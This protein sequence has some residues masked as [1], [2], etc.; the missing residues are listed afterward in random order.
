M[1][2]FS[3]RSVAMVLLV[4]LGLTSIWLRYMQQGLAPA[5]ALSAQDDDVSLQQVKAMQYAPD[6][7]LSY[8]LQAQGYTHFPVRKQSQLQNL[9]LWQ[10][11]PVLSAGT[12][13]NDVVQLSA[14]YAVLEE[15]TQLLRLDGMV[16]LQH[17]ES[18]SRPA[19]AAEGQ[20][21]KVDLFHK[22]LETKQSVV[23]NYN[24]HRLIARD[25]FYNQPLQKWILQSG[26]KAVY[27]PVR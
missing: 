15:A 27:E 18:P 22:T 11:T 19:F 17:A 23:L 13:Y 6:G 3:A 21:F 1:L 8:Q 26:V 25:L 14:N 24:Q 5:P 4:L 7:Q 10:Y 9:Q 16:R 12:L 20:R 2:S